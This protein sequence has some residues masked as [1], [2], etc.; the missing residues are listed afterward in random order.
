MAIVP[1][2]T[3]IEKSECIGNSLVTINGNYTN[4]R[5]SLD[6]VN[7]SII[8]LNAL[9]NGLTTI[10][11]S[12]SSTP[13]RA[14]AWVNFSGRRD[15]TTQQTRLE[16]T[17]RQIFSSYNIATITREDT[18][19]Y[20]GSLINSLVQ[21]F[22]LIGTA[23]PLP[24]GTAGTDASVVNIHQGGLGLPAISPTSEFRILVRNLLG[25]A[26]DPPQVTLA[27]FSI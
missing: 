16:N 8:S 11:T 19:I 23:S 27:I 1:N 25:Q 21:G 7:T 12:I 20:R 2:I 22:T 15:A 18:G 24:P 4:I 3:N 5:N 6:D 9:V 10:I 14:S 17:P 26:I 13:Q